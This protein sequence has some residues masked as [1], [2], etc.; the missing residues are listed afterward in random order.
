MAELNAEQRFTLIT[1]GLEEVIAGDNNQELVELLKTKEHPVIY[2]G[3][4]TTG[5]P[6]M[7]YFVPIYK[8]SDYL[9]GAFMPLERVNRGFLHSFSVSTNRPFPDLFDP[10]LAPTM[11]LDVRL[12][13]SLPISMVSWTTK[14]PTGSFWPIVAL[15]TSLSSRVRSVLHFASDIRVWTYL[16]RETDPGSSLSP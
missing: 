15:T 7:G 13:F 14:S 11:Q 16:N 2:W 3:T 1:R 10:F 5:K 9:A 6:H 8:I 4:A 12:R